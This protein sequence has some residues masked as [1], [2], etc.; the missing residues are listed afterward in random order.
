MAAQKAA[1]L[2]A[3]GVA[4]KGWKERGV[5]ETPRLDKPITLDEAGIDKNLADK[6]R[7]FADRTVVSQFDCGRAMERSSCCCDPAIL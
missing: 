7:K 1:G 6:A 4:E 3:N 5:F 2:M